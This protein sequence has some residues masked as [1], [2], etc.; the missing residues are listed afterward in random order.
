[1]FADRRGLLCP[2]HGTL[3]RPTPPNPPKEGG[4]GSLFLTLLIAPT[5]SLPWMAP[6]P[7]THPS[8]CPWSH[9]PRFGSSCPWFLPKPWASPL[10]SSTPSR[11]RPPTSPG[12]QLPC[13]PRFCFP[14]ARRWLRS[15]SEVRIP[16]PYV[17]MFLCSSQQGAFRGPRCLWGLEGSDG[18]PL[19]PPPPASVP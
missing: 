10:A 5:G 6:P 14:S 17:G 19:P 15:D 7:A 16:C 11:R 4:S 3:D 18:A 1:M 12:A 9:G 8:L 2:P 13:P